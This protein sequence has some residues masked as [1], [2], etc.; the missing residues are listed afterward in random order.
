MLGRRAV[1]ADDGGPQQVF[2]AFG[3][4]ISGSKADTISISIPRALAT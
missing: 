1:E 4:P 2:G 3:L